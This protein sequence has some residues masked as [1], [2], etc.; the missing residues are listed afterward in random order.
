MWTWLGLCPCLWAGQGSGELQTDPA[1]AWL[2]Q[3]LTALG[4]ETGSWTLA[5]MGEPERT[6]QGQSGLTM[7]SSKM[8]CE[9]LIKDKLI[10]GF[11]KKLRKG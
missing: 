8:Y 9:I 5:N 7:P 11:A 3:G 4:A 1:G 10:Y 2:Q 6:R